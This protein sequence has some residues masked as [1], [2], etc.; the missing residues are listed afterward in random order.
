M[1]GV[2]GSLGPESLLV[3]VLN[4]GGNKLDQFLHLSSDPALAGSGS[5][6]VLT[7]R[8]RVVNRTPLGEP[9][10][11]AGPAPG[12]EAG[13]GT[14]TGILSVNLPGAAVDGH[15][16]GVPDLA[17]AGVDG[18]TRVVG[19]PFQLGRGEE[20]TFVIHFRLPG[21]RGAIR[22][23]PSARVPPI[24]WT[25]GRCAGQIARHACLGGESR[26]SVTSEMTS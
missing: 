3:A 11:I 12:T 24:R 10:Y 18:P 1:A 7:V 13:E 6:T 8:V 20:R 17:V 22:V 9:P 25:S 14:Y 15:I 26:C 21:Q 23:E 4:R 16:E 5:D 19:T 2:D